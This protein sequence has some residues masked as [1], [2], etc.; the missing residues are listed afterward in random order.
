MQV[1]T[2]DGEGLH[3]I[4]IVGGGAGGLELATMLGKSL[5]K[6]GKAHITLIDKNR[7]H[8]WKPKLHEIAAGSMDMS[9][10]EVD[11]LAHSH[12]KNFRYR[13]GEMVGL[14]RVNKQVHLA[15][16]IDQE[17]R[18][19]TEERSFSYDT[20]VIAVGSRTNDFGIK[21]VEEHAI[22]LDTPDQAG[23]FHRRLV[24]ACIRAH[25][26]NKPLKPGQLN[27]AIIGA[28]ATGVELAAELRYTTRAL[29]S[30]G[31]DSIEPEKD[32]VLTLIEA[33][34]RILPA[35][36][37][38]LTQSATRVMEKLRV[39]IRT[40]ARVTEVTPDGINLADG[41]FIPA[42][43]IVW[44]AGVRA[45]A[46][47]KDLAGL[48][49]NRINQ[50]LVKPNLQTTQDENIFAIGDCAACQWPGKDA[51]VMIPPRAQ[52][53]HQQAVYMA[54]QIKNRLTG[55]ASKDWKYQDFGSLVSLG[56]HS[57]IGGLM[58]NMSRSIFFIE[59]YVA[60]LMYTSLYKSHQL[61][62]HGIWKVT[63]ETLANL[64]RRNS[65]PEI[66]LH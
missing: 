38:R 41:D 15:P 23:R 26:Q 34:S 46:F 31:L 22:R 10:H 27:V 17:G 14:D 44:A 56:E 25:A 16:H 35:L 6:R 47:L 12:W 57:A 37:E 58:G 9:Q 62:L 11:Y 42:E 1:N 64:I 66:K 13:V 53:A 51:G 60:R 36:P 5:G 39:G 54:K 29:V 20:L 59:G 33:E 18:Q 19:V 2:Q 4:V 3:R 40:H 63:M 65:R 48:E 8:I 7:T 61:T 43:L 28:G 24:N 21:G 45:P 32:I 55:T 49:S 50:L 52:A 30:Y